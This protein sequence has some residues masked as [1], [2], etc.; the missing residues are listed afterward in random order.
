MISRIEGV[1]EAVEGQTVRLGV[2]GVLSIDALVPAYLADRLA[3]AEPGRRI[4]LDTL[5]T[6][7]GSSQ[8]TSF[9]PRLLGFD[10]PQAR[11]F[12]EIFTTVKGLGNRRALRAMAAE[13]GVIA[14]A[15]VAGDHK[16]LERLPE[17]GKRLAQTIVA[18]LSGKVDAFA[19]DAAS[20]E[21]KP[22]PSRLPPVA[23]DAIDTLMALGETA[24]DAERRIQA[25]LG[26]L[27]GAE[28][29]SADQLVAAA[30]R[31]R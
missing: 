14:A 19:L 31:G 10:S 20:I 9:A 15:I 29:P 28:P 4:R 13:P 8:G 30:L 12:F 24:A 16:A 22:R 27:D 3:G 21:S 26:A 11:R 1:L 18:E 25:A 6:L 7:E 23:R 5:L 2:G 17:I